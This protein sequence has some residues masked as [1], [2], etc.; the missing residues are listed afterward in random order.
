MLAS[1][2]P[3]LQRTLDETGTALTVIARLAQPLDVPKQY[4]AELLLLRT[5]ALF[6]SVV[7]ESACR[8][9]CGAVYCDGSSPRL[10][11]HRP[12][13]G[14]DRARH[15]MQRYN[16]NEPRD[17]LRWTTAAEIAANLDKLFP[18]GE[19]FTATILNHGQLIADLRKVRNHIAHRTPSTRKRFQ[20][21]VLQKYGATIPSITPG[22]MLISKRF[23]PPLVEQWSRQV[24]IVTKTAIRG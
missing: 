13:K 10:L 6:E 4:I 7:E 21:V 20:E 23:S 24:Q 12:A 22:R 9:V 2:R 17:R 5:F 19:H 18:R 11:R 1:L 3:Q 8:L 14:I 15:I 16:R